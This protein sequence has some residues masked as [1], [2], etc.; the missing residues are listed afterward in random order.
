EALTEE[1]MKIFTSLHDGCSLLNG[2]FAQWMDSFPNG[3]VVF[4]VG[5]GARAVSKIPSNNLT[6][7]AIEY[8]VLLYDGPFSDASDTNTFKALGEG[9]VDAAQAQEIATQYIGADRVRSVR[10]TG[11]S[12]LPVENFTLEAD[13]ESGLIDIAVTKAGG[14]VLYMLCESGQT[15]VK[16][17]EAEASDMASKFLARNGYEGMQ[18]NY[19][20]QEEGIIT[21]NF[22]SSQ[23]GVLLY[24][25]LVKVEVSLADGL[26]LGVE[27][28]NYLRNHV[29]RQGLTPALSA[30]VA[31]LRVN[32]LLEVIGTKLC[33]IPVNSTEVLCYEFMARHDGLDYLVYIDANTGSERMILKLIE[34][35]NG[36]L[37]Q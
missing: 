28:A 33:L 3:N 23:D 31:M 30:D 27:A 7:P 5:T 11:E 21:M 25:D 36:I 4:D 15:Q 29:P 19:W 12:L 20:N 2:R 26:V 1:D 37:T 14:K 22:A 17:S 8:P 35:D 9:V 13:T 34:E 6:E 10:V 18:V 24:P 32:P 16:I